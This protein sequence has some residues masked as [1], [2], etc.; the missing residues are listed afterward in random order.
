MTAVTFDRILDAARADAKRFDAE[1]GTYQFSNAVENIQW[2]H[3]WADNRDQPK[4]GIAYANWNDIGGYGDRNPY[5]KRARALMR[6]VGDLL[7]GGRSDHE[8]HR[9]ACE[10]SYREPTASSAP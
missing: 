7:E 1:Y 4:G 2:A 9:L 10:A 3:E 6:R 5:S 8:I